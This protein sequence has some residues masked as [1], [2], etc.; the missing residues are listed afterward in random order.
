MLH[1]WALRFRMKYKLEKGEF[2]ELCGI[3]D[4]APG[5]SYLSSYGKRQIPSTKE[6]SIGAS[7]FDAL[8]RNYANPPQPPAAKELS[9]LQELKFLYEENEEEF[10][11]LGG[12]T[13]FF[14]RCVDDSVR[15]RAVVAVDRGGNAESFV[16]GLF[17]KSVH[18]T[19]TVSVVLSVNL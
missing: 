12:V 15:I 11:K 4:T 1:D 6:Q 5:R 2:L 3:P 8:K 16:K 18:G 14:E 10:L 7:V 13:C 17:E 9:H 19:D